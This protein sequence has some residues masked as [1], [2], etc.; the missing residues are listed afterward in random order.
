M[1]LG[2][3]LTVDSECIFTLDSDHRQLWIQSIDLLWVQSID[4]HGFRVGLLCIQSIYQYGI[5][6]YYGLGQV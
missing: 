6:T 4:S 3:R 2:H 5:L 1:D